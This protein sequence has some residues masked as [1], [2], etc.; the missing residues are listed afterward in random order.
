MNEGKELKIL[1]PNTLL[2]KLLI[3]LRQK[4]DGNNSNQLKDDKYCA[5]RMSTIKSPKNFTTT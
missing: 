4:K 5:F 1:T 3:L 2:T